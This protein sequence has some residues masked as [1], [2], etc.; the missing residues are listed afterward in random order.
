MDT[1]C[2]KIL[3]INI[4]HVKVKSLLNLAKRHFPAVLVF[5]NDCIHGMFL[6]GL[7]CYIFK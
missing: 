3:L 7:K 2:K 4:K 5:C 1:F 6:F